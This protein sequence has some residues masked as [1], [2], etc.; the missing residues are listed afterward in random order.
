MD[1]AEPT[2]L[3]VW[4]LLEAHLH[5]QRG[6]YMIVG[7]VTL[8]AFYPLFGYMRSRVDDC[9]IVEDRVRIDNAMRLF[10]FR[11]V[12]QKEDVLIYRAEGLVHRLWLVFEDRIEVRKVDN[13]VELYGIR[14]AVARVMLQ[15]RAY[16]AN[17]RFE[18]TQNE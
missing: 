4:Q 18:D 9:H 11:F 10:G 15:L 6:H 16:I 13:G 2:Q 17:R 7:F 12:E 14:K 3:T 1:L 5:T 8:A